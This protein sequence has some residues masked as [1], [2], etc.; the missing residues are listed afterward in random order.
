M[1]FRSSW[2]MSNKRAEISLYHALSFKAIF[3]VYLMAD[4]DIPVATASQEV[5]LCSDTCIV[6]AMYLD[7]GLDAEGACITSVSSLSFDISGIYCL[8]HP[9]EVFTFSPSKHQSTYILLQ[10][11]TQP[12]VSL[13]WSYYVLHFGI[14]AKKHYLSTHNLGVFTSGRQSIYI[15]LQISTQLSVSI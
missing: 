11:A 8:M 1:P 12:S 7:F 2:D 4:S 14:R 5:R 3:C 10:I 13:W 15:L 9:G 6:A